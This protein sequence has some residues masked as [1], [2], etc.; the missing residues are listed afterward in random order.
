MFLGA[1]EDFVHP[2]VSECKRRFTNQPPNSVPYCE[3]IILTL[4]LEQTISWHCAGARIWS[5]QIMTNFQNF[6]FFSVDL[7][8]RG[9]KPKLAQM[10]T[11]I[12]LCGQRLTFHS[13]TLWNGSQYIC[14]F[15]FNDDWYLYDGMN[16]WEGKNLGLLCS[17]TRFEEPCGFSLSYVIYCM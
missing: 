4:N 10:P 15:N 17:K 6:A 16:E 14:T 11:Q 1:L 13:A 2:G 8:S 7:L 5:E 3:D 12:T 9:G